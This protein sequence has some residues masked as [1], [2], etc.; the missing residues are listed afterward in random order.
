MNDTPLSSHGR[1]NALI[2]VC[3]VALLAPLFGPL[4]TGRVFVSS[5]LV[6]FHLP[7]RYLYQQALHAGDTVLWTPSI[8]AG[9]YL[10]GEGQAGLSIHFISCSTG[11]CRSEW[12]S[13]S[14]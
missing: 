9:L 6:W 4:L 1:L 12:H 10:H 5:D 2:A 3:S 11:S 14:N 8:F 13:T 7:L